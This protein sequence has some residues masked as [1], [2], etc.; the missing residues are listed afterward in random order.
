[1]NKLLEQTASDTFSAVLQALCKHAQRISRATILEEGDCKLLDI[2][3]RFLKE[4]NISLTTAGQAHAKS[5]VEKLPFT[6]SAL[7]RPR[8]RKTA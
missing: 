6:P 1:M 8:E 4:N 3:S 7:E 2:A 5:A